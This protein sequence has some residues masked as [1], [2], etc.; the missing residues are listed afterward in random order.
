MENGSHF[1]PLSCSYITFKKFTFCSG[2]LSNFLWPASGPIKY[3]WGLLDS[4]E[5]WEEASK[6]N[7]H[8][9]KNLENA[10]FFLHFLWLVITN[11]NNEFA[12]EPSQNAGIK[13]IVMAIILFSIFEKRDRLFSLKQFT[14][15]RNTRFSLK[16]LF[17]FSFWN[18]NHKL[19]GFFC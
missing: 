6:N 15:K 2:K 11:L 4:Q 5:L 14:Q 9:L 7:V 16:V 18:W 19:R 12:F 3:E 8:L 10:C 17:Y 13:S 1:V